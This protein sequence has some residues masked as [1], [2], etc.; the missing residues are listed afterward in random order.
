MAHRAEEVRAQAAQFQEESISQTMLLT[1][2][3]TFERLAQREEQSLPNDPRRLKR[4]A[5]G[6][7]VEP[8]TSIIQTRSQLL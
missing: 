4:A 8:A 3:E 7:A 1:T 2:A 5:A 6:T